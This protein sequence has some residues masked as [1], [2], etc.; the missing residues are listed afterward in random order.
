MP[1]SYPLTF[2]S[3]VPRRVSMMARAIVA[4]SPSPFTFE[5][6]VQAHA[7]QIWEA[8]LDFPPLLR[9]DAE[10][11]NAFRLKMNGFEGV[12]SFTPPVQGTPRGVATGTPQVDGGVAALAQD[13]PTKGW[14]TGITGIVKAGDFIQLGSG[15]LARLHKVLDDADSDGSG[16]ATL[17]IWP[18]T[19]IAYANSATIVAVNPVGAFSLADNAMG[20]TVEEAQL[21]GIEFSLI[22]AL[23]G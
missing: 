1:V 23:R 5:D 18:R 8:A 12:C 19:R 16:N 11:L 22:E 21:Y 13:L 15:L 10:L 6:Q 14:T 20:W 17:T 7:G 2:P 9:E 4:R 3:L